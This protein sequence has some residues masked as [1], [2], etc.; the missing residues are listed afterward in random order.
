MGVVI[1]SVLDCRWEMLVTLQKNAYKKSAAISL[2]ISLLI[3]G[4]HQYLGRN[5]T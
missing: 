2:G 3:S 5:L 4:K 1:N